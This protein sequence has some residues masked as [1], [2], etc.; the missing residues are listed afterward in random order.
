MRTHTQTHTDARTHTCSNTLWQICWQVWVYEHSGSCRFLKFNST[1]Q[2][3][4]RINSSNHAN[5]PRSPEYFLAITTHTILEQRGEMSRWS[6]PLPELPSDQPLGGSKVR[7]QCR[8]TAPLSVTQSSW[9]AAGQPESAGGERVCVSPSALW[10][11]EDDLLHLKTTQ[12]VA[13]LVT[14]CVILRVET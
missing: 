4:G 12:R 10:L 2:Q 11:L 14:R 6:Q 8:P 13:A 3:T 7:F 9:M 5:A 1:G